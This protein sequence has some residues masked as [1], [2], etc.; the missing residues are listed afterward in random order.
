MFVTLI[1][2]VHSKEPTSKDKDRVYSYINNY[3]KEVSS[4]SEYRELNETFLCYY[5]NAIKFKREYYL[6]SDSSMGEAFLG[7]DS[8]I[9]FNR[10]RDSALLFYLEKRKNYTN[11]RFH[12][13]PN[14]LFAYKTE[15]GWRF[16]DG[17]GSAIYLDINY[18]LKMTRNNQRLWFA[19]EGRWLKDWDTDQIKENPNFIRQACEDWCGPC[20]DERDSLN[21]DIYYKDIK[22]HTAPDSLYL[23]K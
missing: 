5:S 23:C 22:K 16:Y 19:F 13:T 7:L 21:M 9:I 2:C 10:S 15:K 17:C 20:A 1:S 6:Q 11:E 3:I 12:Y 8:L 18:I 14:K 4:Y